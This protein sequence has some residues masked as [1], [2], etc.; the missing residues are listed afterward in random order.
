MNR[1][2]QEIGYQD[3]VRN[4]TPKC[5]PCRRAHADKRADYR[6][7]RYL[8]H[9][10][11]SVD[12]TG[13]RRRIQALAAIGW[14][15]AE[16]SRRLG[17]HVSAAH[18]MTTRAWVT[19][20]TAAKVAALYDE[21][22]MIPGSNNRARADAQRKGWVSPLAWDE[23]DLDDPAAKPAAH[24]PSQP[25]RPRNADMEER[26]LELTRCGLSAA[27]IA[28]R[29]GTYKRYVTRVRSRDRDGRGIAS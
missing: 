6:R 9:A 3:H 7:R 25:G 10:P 16:Q 8:H 11:L 12:A 14:S 17:M 23:E 1:C 26:V 19:V 24:V 2:G 21:L 4:R 18:S 22:S 29:L 13:T 15:L 27:E 28:I 5:A 20:A